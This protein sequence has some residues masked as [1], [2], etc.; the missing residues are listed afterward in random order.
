VRT[1]H[2]RGEVVQDASGGAVLMRGTGQDITE[3]KKDDVRRARHAARLLRFSRQL[4]GAQEAERQRISRELHDE[5]GQLLTA[6]RF[7]LDASP[8]R[9]ARPAVDAPDRRRPSAEKLRSIV[10]ELIERTRMLSVS[11]CPPL[12]EQLGLLPTL[13]WH[14]DSFGRQTGINVRLEHRG[15]DGR[16]PQEVELGAFRVVQEALT[17]VTRHAGVGDA[18]VRVSAETG[19]LH[20][21]VEDRGRGFDPA[22]QRHQV[23]AGISGMRERARL[24]GGTLEV[25]SA[26]GKGTRVVLRLPVRKDRSPEGP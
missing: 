5:M 24:L 16:F 10:D 21:A 2:A 20:V 3:R 22:V 18:S 26:P 13:L 17:N 25:T 12:L 9:A 7:M 19:L 8:V 1:L 6:L 4:V 23:T 11:L 14:L 15:I